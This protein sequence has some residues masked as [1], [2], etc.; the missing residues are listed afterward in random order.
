MCWE[1]DEE[2]GTTQGESKGG[3]GK[4]TGVKGGVR[5]VSG[6]ETGREGPPLS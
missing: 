4:G 5:R 2:V 3:G 6:G 1:G